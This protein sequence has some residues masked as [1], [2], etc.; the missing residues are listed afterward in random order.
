MRMPQT[1]DA[2]SSTIGMVPRSP[3]HADYA[4]RVVQMLDGRILQEHRRAAWDEG[5]GRSDVAQLSH[6]R[7]ARACQEPRLYDHQ[8]RRAVA[9]DRGV[10]AEDRKSVV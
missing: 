9:G 1:E 4:G 8:H 7:L 2:E 3:A 6:G 5:R 10:P